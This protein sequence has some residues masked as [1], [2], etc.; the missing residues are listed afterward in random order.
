MPFQFRLE[1][2]TGESAEAPTIESAVPNWHP[3]DRV[4][5]NPTVRYRVLELR[6][7]RPR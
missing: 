4:F 2:A 3:G 1:L 5:I 7:R 6:E